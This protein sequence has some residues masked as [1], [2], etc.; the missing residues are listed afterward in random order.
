MCNEAINWAHGRIIG[1]K[2]WKI[3]DRR[4]KQPIFG[5]K[6]SKKKFLSLQVIGKMMEVKVRKA[7]PQL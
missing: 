3:W 6:W 2:Q 7:L 1:A 4:G 5:S